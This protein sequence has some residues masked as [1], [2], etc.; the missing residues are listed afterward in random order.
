[1]MSTVRDIA[2]AAAV[3]AA[4]TFGLGGIYLARADEPQNCRVGCADPV[5]QLLGTPE[6]PVLADPTLADLMLGGAR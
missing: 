5:E 4:I 2:A 1:M 3:G 6:V